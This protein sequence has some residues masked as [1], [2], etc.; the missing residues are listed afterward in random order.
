[1]PRCYSGPMLE[2]LGLKGRQELV[3]FLSLIL[4]VA[5]TP[6]GKEAS[7]PLVLGIY[8]TLIFVI[9][10]CYAWN[11]RSRLPRLSPLFLGGVMALGTTM[12]ISILRGAGSLCESAY[13]VYESMLLIIAF[14]VLAH[15]ATGSS[16]AWKHAILGAVVLIN[17]GYV[18]GALMIEK[19]PLFGPFVNP[20]YLASF[21]LP[22]LA[23]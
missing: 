2:R 17:L 8:R 3:L 7:H 20:N 15:G 6:A 1:M 16:P 14:I 19:R 23:I 22:G 18:A 21:L 9:V 12:L 10:G 4:L 13:L 11:D 5:L